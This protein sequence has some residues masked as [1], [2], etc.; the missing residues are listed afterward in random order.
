MP[1]ENL[2]KTVECVPEKRMFPHKEKMLYAISWRSKTPWSL[3]TA[4]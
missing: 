3:V 2:S 1:F 4:G